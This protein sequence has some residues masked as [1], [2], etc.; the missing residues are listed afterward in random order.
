MNSIDSRDRAN[1]IESSSPIVRDE[2]NSQKSPKSKGN[3]KKFGTVFTS[4]FLAIF[5]AEMGDKTQLAT[6]LMS[7]Q[8][9]A[10]WVVFAGAAI[11]LIGTSLI[12][13]LLGYWLSKRVS[14]ET[15]DLF[16]GAILLIV[17]VLLLWDVV[18]G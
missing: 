6:L 3:S 7:A 15:M 16:A 9:D 10:P 4:T 17:S 8:A 1:D 5:L 13:V 12:G 11:A 14:G 18:Q 2:K